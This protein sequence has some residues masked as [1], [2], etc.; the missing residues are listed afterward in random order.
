MFAPSKRFRAYTT[1]QENKTF[2]YLIW[3]ANAFCWI[4][5]KDEQEW[6]NIN[7]ILNMKRI[8]W[9]FLCAKWKQNAI[10]EETN[11]PK[12]DNINLAPHICSSLNHRVFRVCK[13]G[14]LCVPRD[15]SVSY[16]DRFP[17][18][19]AP[20]QWSTNSQQIIFHDHASHI[21]KLEIDLSNTHK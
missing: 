15:V 8:L 1:K 7:A 19:M 13:S 11:Q 12:S 3:R 16:Y 18:D 10:K 2:I 14:N 6:T 5:L 17:G 9:E 21:C 4:H 20:Y